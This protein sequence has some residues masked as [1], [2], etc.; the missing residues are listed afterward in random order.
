MIIMIIVLLVT[1]TGERVVSL[2]VRNDNMSVSPYI[3]RGGDHG[4]GKLALDAQVN[5]FSQ[6]Q[7]EEDI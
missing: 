5:D 6:S 1:R 7:F 4:L 2:H 3:L